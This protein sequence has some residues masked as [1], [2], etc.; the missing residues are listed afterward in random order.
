MKIKC[1]V[2]DDEPLA[3]RVIESHI[4]K[5]NNIE[6]V[7]KCSNAIDALDILKNNKIDL[8]FLDIQMPEL[9]GLEFLNTLQNPPSVIFTTAYRNYAIDAFELDVLD[10]LLKPITF[11][12]FLKAI[13]KFYKLL[14]Y[15]KPETLSNVSATQIESEPF[16]YI[17]RNKTMIKILLKDILFIESLKDY[18]RIH[19]EDDSY[20][21]KQQISLIEKNLPEEQFLRVHKSFIINIEKITTFSPN[22]IGLKD[23][24]ISIGRSYKAYV[25]NKLNYGKNF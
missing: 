23:K 16:I 6:I 14:S 20:M 12:R 8:I 18:I 7:A 11:E 1:I 15:K 9:T 19:T 10:Y 13:N 21:T 3:I 22:Y 4:E 24:K 5:L 2:V 17:K 25:L